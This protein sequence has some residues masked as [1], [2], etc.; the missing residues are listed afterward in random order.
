MLRQFYI[1]AWIFLL[2]FGVAYGTT[3]FLMWILGVN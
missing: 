2:W 3:K 1:Y